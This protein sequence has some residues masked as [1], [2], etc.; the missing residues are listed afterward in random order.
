MMMYI[1]CEICGI[2]N[3]GEKEY[4]AEARRRDDGNGV[5]MSEL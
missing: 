3:L 4:M 5:A 1:V 2:H